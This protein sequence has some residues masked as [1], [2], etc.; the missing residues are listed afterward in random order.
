MTGVVFVDLR[1]A[2]KM[3]DRNILI[4]KLGWY[5]IEG[6]VLKWFKNYL[7]NRTQRVK[8]N[9][10]LSEPID[11]KLEV[12]Q[13]SVLEPLLFLIYI[14]DIKT[15]INDTC[16]IRLFADDALIYITDY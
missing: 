14:N 3:V 9:G 10:K 5:G 13:R 16:K 11:V 7:E 15:V 12:P 4:R 1:R 6:V 2:F 8:F